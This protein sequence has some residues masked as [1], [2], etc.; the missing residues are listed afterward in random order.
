MDESVFFLYTFW[1]PKT[2]C[3]LTVFP[4]PDVFKWTVPCS[5][6]V[7]EFVIGCEL[8]HFIL[9]NA[10][11]LCIMNDKCYKQ[12]SVCSLKTVGSERTK[13]VHSHRGTFFCTNYSSIIIAQSKNKEISARFRF[14][15]DSFMWA[16]NDEFFFAT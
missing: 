16:H 14:V 8:L 1:R 13:V 4:T 12:F 6:T 11:L 10:A 9:R 3:V 5:L 2:V 7:L 15:T